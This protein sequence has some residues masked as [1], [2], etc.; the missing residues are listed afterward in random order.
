MIITDEVSWQKENASISTMKNYTWDLSHNLFDVCS[1]GGPI[2]PYLKD[3]SLCRQNICTLRG[4]MI[5]DTGVGCNNQS[6]GKKKK[7]QEILH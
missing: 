5:S 2:P 3:A 7:Q 4:E 6:L 1:D